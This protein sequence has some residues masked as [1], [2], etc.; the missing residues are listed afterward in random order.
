M[1]P[2]LLEINSNIYKDNNILIIEKYEIFELF[3]EHIIKIIYGININN[4]ERVQENL[5]EFSNI[6]AIALNS[7]NIFI[8][9]TKRNINQILIQFPNFKILGL[10]RTLGTH[11]GSAEYIKELSDGRT[12]ISVGNDGRVIFY[13]DFLQVKE[14]EVEEPKEIYLG[15]FDMEEDKNVAIFSNKN[16]YK[17]HYENNDSEK[18]FKFYDNDESTINIINIIYIKSDIFYACT[19]KGIYIYREFAENIIDKNIDNIYKKNYIGGIKINDKTAVFTSN[20][21]LVNGEDKIIYCINK[22][23]YDFGNRYSFTISPNNLSLMNIP[24][25]YNDGNDKLLFAA[26]KKYKRGQ[27]NGILFIILKIQNDNIYNIYKEFYDTINYEVYCFC[28][29]Y[30]IS[31]DKFLVDKI[32]E[33]ETEYF[34]VGGFDLIKREGLIKLYKVIYNEDFK[35]IKI[36][37]ILDLNIEKNLITNDKKIFKGFKGPINCISQSKK[38]GN[39]LIS[40]YDGNVYLLSLAM[41]ENIKKMNDIKFN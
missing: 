18:T 1:N 25:E 5:P 20:K 14:K 35:K 22:N 27:K 23:I 2:I 30:E 36:K 16:L 4:N 29:I 40:C 11:K 7:N 17:M 26:C 13:K 31:Y 41:I 10:I 6:S 8:S 32:S 15:F 9:S 21:L 39:I 38:Y 24:K 34:L 3:I 33:R 37:Y 19:D 28:P 12:C